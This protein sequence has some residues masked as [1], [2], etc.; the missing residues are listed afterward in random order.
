MNR[1]RMKSR[2]GVAV[3]TLAAPLFGIATSSYGQFN[4]R[5]VGPQQ[6]GSVVDRAEEEAAYK[7]FNKEGDPDAKIEF[8]EAFDR[9]YP[10]SGYQKSVD[11]VLVTLYYNK[12]DWPK[13]YDTGHKLIAEDPDNVPILELV[14]WVIP[15]QYNAADPGEPAKLDESEK[16][17]KHALDL[18]AAMK[19]P[20]A[21]TKDQFNNAQDSLAWRAHGGLGMTYFRRK[22][23]ANSVKEL[24]IAVTE[25][26]PET[27]PVDLY[28]LGVDLQNL[29]RVSEAADAFEKCSEIPGKLQDRCKQTADSMMKAVR[30]A[31]PSDLQ[32]RQSVPQA[33]AANVNGEGS[34]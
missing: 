16:Y 12:E 14:G 10:T 26:S 30:N 27:D 20:R 31:S 32:A 29:N 24:E 7:A 21:V 15:R 2:I 22:D 9:A 19:K 23:F 18:I 11:S 33:A 17:E 4:G 13:F 6:G 25:E 28:I 8:G 34:K 3:L 5:G 1:R